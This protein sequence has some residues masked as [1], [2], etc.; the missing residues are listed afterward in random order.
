MY[1]LAENFPLKADPFPKEGKKLILL[2]QSDLYQVTGTTEGEKGR[3]NISR[4][5]ST[6][7]CRQAGI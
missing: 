5:I 7:L 2:G 4:S 1:L 6:K 3:R